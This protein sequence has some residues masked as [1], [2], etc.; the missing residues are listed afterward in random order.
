[1]KREKGFTLIE[2]LIVVAII[3]ILAAIAVPNFLEAQIRSKVSRVKGEHRSIA[4]ALEA[5]YTDHNKYPR[6]MHSGWYPG[7]NYN[8]EDVRG[9][10]SPCITTPISYISKFDYIDPF[11]VTDTANPADERLYSYHDFK[12]WEE[13]Y[14][15]SNWLRA[16]YEFY[17]LWRLGSVGP[18]RTYYHPE[19][20]GWTYSPQLVYDATNGTVSMGNIW[21]CQKIFDDQQPTVA[22]GLITDH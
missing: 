16:A 19:Y 12:A 5:Y 2:L 9:I 1:M 10:L 15:L 6:E 13:N 14:G 4:T 17:G 11:Q 21:R 22:S 7:D 3:A 18:D 8:G 20:P